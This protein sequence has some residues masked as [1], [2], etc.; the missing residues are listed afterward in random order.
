MQRKRRARNLHD[1]LCYREAS[2]EVVADF[3]FLFLSIFLSC[4]FLGN[5]LL[6]SWGS[7]LGGEQKSKIQFFHNYCVVEELCIGPDVVWVERR[8]FF[9]Y[10]IYLRVVLFNLTFINLF[11]STVFRDSNNRFSYIVPLDL[12]SYTRENSYSS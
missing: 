11:M 12:L 6:L 4:L 10:T 3:P 5:F 7:E 1:T 2:N 8:F 9:C